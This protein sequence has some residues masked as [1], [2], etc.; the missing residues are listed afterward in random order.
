ML[1]HCLHDILHAKYIVYYIAIN[2]QKC[3]NRLRKIVFVRYKNNEI[4]YYLFIFYLASIFELN[5][6]HT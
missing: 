2:L 4:I 1:N 6:I 5:V 3:K